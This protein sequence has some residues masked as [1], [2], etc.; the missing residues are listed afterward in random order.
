[1]GFGL[2]MGLGLIIGFGINIVSH[3]KIDNKYKATNIFIESKIKPSIKDI[4]IQII[5]SYEKFFLN[6]QSY[7]FLKFKKRAGLIKLN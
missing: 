2:R 5:F 6:L 7:N 1:M 4:I 3:P